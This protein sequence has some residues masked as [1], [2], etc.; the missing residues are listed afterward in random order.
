M[1]R[2]RKEENLGEEKRIGKNGGVEKEKNKK[3]ED[4]DNIDRPLVLLT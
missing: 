4:N 1:R 3:E 2:R